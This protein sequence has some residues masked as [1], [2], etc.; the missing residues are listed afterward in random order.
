MDRH[1]CLHGLHAE[2]CIERIGYAVREHLSAVTVD[3]GNEVKESLRHRDVGY[4]CRKD[5]P[6]PDHL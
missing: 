4:V 5:P 3:D 6:G 2:L 1:G